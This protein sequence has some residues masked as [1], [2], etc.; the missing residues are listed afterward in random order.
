MKTRLK[1]KKLKNCTAWR[2][3]LRTPGI[4]SIDAASELTLFCSPP[5]LP[6]RV[7]DGGERKRAVP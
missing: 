1:M 3:A 5:S 2:S 7:Y 4:T 6:N